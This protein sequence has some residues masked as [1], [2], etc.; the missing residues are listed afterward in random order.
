MATNKLEFELIVPSRDKEEREEKE[1]SFPFG[2]YREAPSKG[3]ILKV[4]ESL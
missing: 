4:K 2:S 1:S 3:N